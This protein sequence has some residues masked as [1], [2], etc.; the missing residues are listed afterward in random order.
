MGSVVSSGSLNVTGTTTWSSD[1]RYSNI[2]LNTLNARIIV[3]GHRVIQCDGFFTIGSNCTIQLNANSSLRLYMTGGNL[4]I[5]GTSQVNANTADPTRLHI[6]F[7]VPGWPVSMQNS[8]VF[9]GSIFN[10]GGSLTI[11]GGSTPAPTF[12]GVYHGTTITTT[13]T[14][15]FRADASFGSTI[16][17]TNL[18]TTWRQTQ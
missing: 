4:W 16:A 7:D 1:V 9:H 17:S 18:L 11:T 10:P 12:F 14:A 2:T 6:Y 13:S 15:L 3:S 8:A 5:T